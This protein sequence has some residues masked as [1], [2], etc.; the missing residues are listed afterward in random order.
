MIRIFLLSTL[1][2]LTPYTSFA[3]FII[4]P[5]DDDP[6]PP[7]MPCPPAPKEALE[8]VKNYLTL[9]FHSNEVESLGLDHL[10]PDD[11]EPVTDE[12][13]CGEIIHALD[14]NPMIDGD[15][16]P[17]GWHRHFLKAGMHYFIIYRVIQPDD[18]SVWVY[19]GYGPMHI[20]GAFDYN[21]ILSRGP[22]WDPSDY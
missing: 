17:P 3:Q 7:A 4:P 1:F 9:N 10:E 5:G 21:V 20:L 2:L 11:V 14:T 19:G 18:G 13:V 8:R 15:P 6:D 12:A 22:D 16:N